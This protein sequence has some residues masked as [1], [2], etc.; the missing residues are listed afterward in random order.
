MTAPTVDTARF[1]ADL[2]ELRQIGRF[3]TGVHRPTYSPQDMESREWLM[4]KMAEIGL[5]PE[6]DGVGTVIGR[7]EGAGRR[8]LAGSHIESQNEAGWLD[9]A[10]GVV[11]ALALARSGLAVDPIAF[12][13]EEGHFDVGFLGSRSA[14]GDLTEAEID[15]SRNRTD[16][17]PLRAALKAA[18]L[19]GRPRL[20][21]DP[22]R[23]RGYLEMHIEQGTT[24]ENAGERVGVVTGIVAIWQFRLIVEGAQDH[25]GGTTMAE[26]RDAGLTAVRLLAAIDAEFPRV[27]G[28]RS[29]WTTGRIA[30]DPGAPS[31][32]PGTA[33]V[34]FQFRDVEIAVLERMEDCLRRLVQESNR[35]ERCHTTIEVLSRAVPAVC[36]PGLMDALSAAAERLAPGAWRR[37]PSGAGHDAQNLARIMPAAMLFT[38]SIGGISHHW[39]EDTKEEDLALGVE[40]LFEAARSVLAG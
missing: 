36:D 2:H 19:E 39:S 21:L 26:R 1:L 34:L 16:G 4:R 37:M 25:A 11:A 18:G 5:A 30:L 3:K 23:Y 32:I 14:I 7:G 6:M 31:I 27:C 35:R 15:G 22:A 9:G 38:P 13:D 40:V 8:L 33:D 10:L 24:L 17:T 28:E 20:T 12:A 29:T